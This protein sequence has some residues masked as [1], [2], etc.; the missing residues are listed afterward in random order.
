MLVI[1][2]DNKFKTSVSV[3]YVFLLYLSL[4]LSENPLMVDFLI[5]KS[6]WT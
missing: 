3:G 4:S 5:F 6:R 2:I 1:V